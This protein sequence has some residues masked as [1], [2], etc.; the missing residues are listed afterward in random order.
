MKPMIMTAGPSYVRED[1]R[2][3]LSRE[4]TNPDLDIEFFELYKDTCE[5]LGQLMET[6]NKIIIMAGEGILG[7]EAACASLIEEG[8][9]VLCID[10]GIF[11]KGF[12]DFAEIYGGEVVYFKSDYTKGIDVEK[13]KAFLEE[14]ND[15][16][17]ATVVG[18]ETPSGIKNPLNEIG[19]IL[20]SYGILT[21][22]DIVSSVGGD[23]IK[24]DESNIDIGIVGSQKCI[25]AP[26][27]LTI[28]SISDNAWNSMKARKTPIKGFY[29]NLTI[30]E[31]WYENKWFP[32]TQ[33]VSDIF[34]LKKAVEN[35]LEENDYLKRHEQLAKRIRYS[36]IE[37]GLELYPEK[38]FSN[39]VTVIKVPESIE[40]KEIYETMLKN[41]VMISGAFD[42][43]EGKVFRIG[44]MG[45]N[46]REEK[47]YKTLKALDKTMRELGINLKKEIHK[48]F[49]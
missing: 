48:S 10:N 18:C 15:F 27:G 26:P 13:L 16:K 42:I 12:G 33:S 34:A 3:E 24:V 29:C 41:G 30:W 28:V 22:A 7:L 49:I 25:S 2:R 21:V 46:A 20:N 11:G 31:D 6:K 14:D 17:I 9:R 40:Y 39:C 23:E 5:K 44:N 43:L 36:I 37:S 8:D 32:Y 19:P 47:I 35:I 4:I 38:D 1:V 45:E